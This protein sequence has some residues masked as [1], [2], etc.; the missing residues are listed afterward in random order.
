M[1]KFMLVGIFIASLF[2][3]CVMPDPEQLLAQ[4]TDRQMAQAFL[5]STKVS[6]Y[7]RINSFAS[8]PDMVVMENYI[9]DEKGHIDIDIADA[10]NEYSSSFDSSTDLIAQRYIKVAKSRGSMVKMY[11]TSVNTAI[12]RVIPNSNKMNNSPY[13][14]YDLD[15]AFIEFDKDGKI[16]SILIRK[17][18]FS[19]VRMF[20]GIRW[21]HHRD[22]Q[23]IYGNKIRTIEINIGN[24]VLE[25]GYIRTL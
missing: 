20:G 16:K 17:H 7:E 22:S 10:V 5:G 11:K 3:G 4:S 9:S 8:T 6:K 21:L 14:R 1:K 23:I 25:N 13:R 12:S 18:V 2:S 15:P 19:S 24:D